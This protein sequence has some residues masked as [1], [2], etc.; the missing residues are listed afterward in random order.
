[1]SLS[2][3][4]PNPKRFDLVQTAPWAEQGPVIGLSCELGSLTD[5]QLVRVMRSVQTEY[6]KRFLTVKPV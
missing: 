3:S 1:M 2:D 4:F 6:N 5:A